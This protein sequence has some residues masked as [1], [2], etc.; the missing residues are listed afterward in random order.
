MSTKTRHFYDCE[1]I[2]DGRTIDL[3]SIGI[4]CDDGREYYAVSSEFDASRANEWV[5]QNVLPHLVPPEQRKSR[6]VIAMEVCAFLLSGSQK[7]ELWAYYA[8]Y[9]HVA[10]CQLFGRMIDLP[11]GIPWYT[12]DLK[13]FSESLGSPKHPP[14][15][16][17]EHH[18]LEDARWNRDLYAFLT[19]LQ[20]RAL[21]GTIEEWHAKVRDCL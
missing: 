19:R 17:T 16:S 2:E 21:E 6:A 7:P 20:R 11:K 4:A 3:V 9:D 14:Q 15:S 5:Q 10:L 18:A 1:F 8:A 13:Q 12:N